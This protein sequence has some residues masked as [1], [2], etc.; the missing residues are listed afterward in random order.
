MKFLSKLFQRNK[1]QPVS[2]Q[3]YIPLGSCPGCGYIWYKKW[4]ELSTLT[5][6]AKCSKCGHYEEKPIE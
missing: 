6:H 3:P 5:E 1:P 4:I 2:K